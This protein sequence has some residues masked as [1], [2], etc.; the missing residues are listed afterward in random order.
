VSDLSLRLKP[1]KASLDQPLN[2]RSADKPAHPRAAAPSGR[3]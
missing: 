1:A 3:R 2:A